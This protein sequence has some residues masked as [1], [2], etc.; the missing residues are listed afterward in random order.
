[1][2]LANTDIKR[3]IF[4]DN[5]GQCTLNR[6]NY[7]NISCSGHKFQPVVVCFPHRAE[8]FRMYHW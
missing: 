1:M 4:L 8:A 7:G 2:T 3:M 6:F 5:W